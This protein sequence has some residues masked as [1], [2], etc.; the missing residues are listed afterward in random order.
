MVFRI[1][2]ELNIARDLIFVLIF[3][4]FKRDPSNFLKW[5]ISPFHPWLYLGDAERQKILLD[6]Q[7]RLTSQLSSADAVPTIDG[8]HI[9][10]EKA[11]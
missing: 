4:L 8:S 9:K 2:A 5:R 7:S 10:T 3:F 6:I 1:L 11:S